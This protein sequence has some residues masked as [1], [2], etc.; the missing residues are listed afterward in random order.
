VLGEEWGS[1]FRW[2]VEHTALPKIAIC[3]G[4]PQFHGQYNLHY[5]RPD[6]MQVIEPAREKLVDYVGDMLVVCNSHQA[7][8]EWR[9]RNSRVIWHG[10]DPTEFPAATYRRGI[11]SPIGPNTISRPHYRGYFLYQKVFEQF[12]KEY[13]PGTLHVPDPSPLFQDNAY[14]VRKYRNYVDEIRSYSVYFNPTLRS[15]MPRSRGEPMMCG[16]ATVSA[17]NHDVDMF[18][19]NGVNGFYSNEAIELREQLLYLC[20]NPDAARKIGQQGRRT[21]LDLFNHDR[22][23]AEWDALIRSVV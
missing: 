19:R 20:R 18:I 22:F 23:L 7:A 10:F 6:L 14:A 16:V 13:R 12:P 2:F 3:H 11:L 17:N 21:A 5:D 15:P 9:F 1:A 4:T 8:R